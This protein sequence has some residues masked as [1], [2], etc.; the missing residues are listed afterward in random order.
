MCTATLAEAV[1]ALASLGA[2]GEDE[3]PMVTGTRR[4]SEAAYIGL[5]RNRA[6]SLIAGTVYNLIRIAT[7]DA[8]AV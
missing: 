4:G 7:L 5:Q 8:Q 1:T 2:L 6:C 3:K